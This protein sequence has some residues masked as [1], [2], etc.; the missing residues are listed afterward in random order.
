MPSDFNKTVALTGATGFLGAYLIDHLVTEGYHV[1]ALTRRPQKEKDGVTWVTGD[2]ELPESL[3]LLAQGASIFIHGAGLT[4]ALSLEGFRRVNKMG[5][6]NALQAAKHSKV[7]KFIMISSMAAREPSLSHYALSKWEGDQ[8]LHTFKWPFD[9]MIIRPGGIYGP[10][11]YEFLPMFKMAKQG[12][13]FAAGSQNNR[14]ALIHADDMARMIVQ[15]LSEDFNQSTIEGGDANSQGYTAQDLKNRV[16]PL[17]PNG[18]IKTLTIP[19]LVLKLIGYINSL[20][21]ILTRKPELLSHKKI[22]ELTHSDW[23]VQ[24]PPPFPFKPKYTLEEGFSET[25]NWYKQ[26]NL[27]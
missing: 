2:V 4:K 19:W 22:N 27:L 18:Q 17:Y 7:K 11:D 20:K 14:F 26:K 13:L 16:A 24:S 25:I 3:S 8:A 12:F 21:A 15:Q 5:A 10:G 6:W 1:R 9:W 23:T